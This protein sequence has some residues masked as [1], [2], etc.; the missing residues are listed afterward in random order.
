MNTKVNY[1]LWM[2]M[3]CQCSF[4]PGKKCTILVSDVNEGDYAC[5]GQRAYGKS[6]YPPLNFVINVKVL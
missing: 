5:V 1:G 2:I 4:I 6:P 3:T